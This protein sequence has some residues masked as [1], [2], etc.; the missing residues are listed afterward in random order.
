[1]ST[2]AIGDLQGCASSFDAL[3]DRIAFDPHIDR[4]WLVGDLV[5]RG[6]DSLGALRRVMAQGDTATVVLGNHDLHLLAVAAGVRKRGRNDT[7]DA[8]L[9]APD[10]TPLLDWLRHRPLAHRAT[11]AGRDVLM[12]HAGVLPMWSA[13]DTMRHAA[14]LEAALRADSW[15]DTLARV[16]GNQPD[17]WDEALTGD[18]RL[19]VIVNALTRLR[20]CSED[21]RIDFDA[22]DAPAIAAQAPMPDPLPVDASTHAPVSAFTQPPAGFKPWF[23]IAGRRTRDA[24]TIFGHWSTLGVMVRDDVIALDSGCVWGRELSAVRLRDRQVVSVRCPEAAG[25]E[26]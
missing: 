16:F 4:L 20:F 3:L 14:E 13:D 19:R 24:L 25:R 21:G 22:K 6:P 7:I 23:D 8:V 11:I 9:E 17:R 15:C 10:A 12:V 1:M 5:N 2:Y 26:D 18:A